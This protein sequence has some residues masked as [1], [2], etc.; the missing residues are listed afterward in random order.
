M[1]VVWLQI[2]FDEASRVGVKS[3][4]DLSEMIAQIRIHKFVLSVCWI[5]EGLQNDCNEELQE[6]SRNDECVRKEEGLGG[7]AIS[8]ADWLIYLIFYE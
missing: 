2:F 1:V 7:F 6:N 8:A 4:P 5:F 3:G